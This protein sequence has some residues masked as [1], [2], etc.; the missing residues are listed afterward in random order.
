MAT[1]PLGSVTVVPP[2]GLTVDITITRLG[3]TA[4]GYTDAYS[5]TTKS[6]VPTGVTTPQTWFLPEG[7]YQ[8]SAKI[9]GIEIATA[10]G[11]VRNFTVLASQGAIVIPLSL[12][13]DRL[14]LV[15][16]TPITTYS[17]ALTASAGLTVASGQILTAGRFRATTAAVG[18]ITMGA[19]AGTTPPAA[20]ITNTP[21]P[22]D[23]RGTIGWGTGTTPGTGAQASVAFN[24]AMPSVPAVIL[25]PMNAATA[26]LA[27]YG[28][29]STGAFTIS[30]SVAPAAS[31]A[32]NTFQTAYLIVL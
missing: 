18:T 12:D 29:A 21:T 32:A 26:A 3:G 15:A 13:G 8:L 6:L 7:G 20:T 28:T 31:A 16:A 2:T 5:V 30:A 24:S 25:S 1:L 10:G 14:A 11:A 23:T 17:A 22:N 27:L 4:A 9:N 19:G